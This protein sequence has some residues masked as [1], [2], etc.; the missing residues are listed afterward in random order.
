ME[1]AG[2]PLVC[3]F[4]NAEATPDHNQEDCMEANSEC[5]PAVMII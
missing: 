4:R 1:E 3:T 2:K 5:S